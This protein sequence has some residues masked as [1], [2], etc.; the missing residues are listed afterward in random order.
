VR[1]WRKLKYLLPWHRRAQ[2][3]DMREE[4]DSL[5][6]LAAPGELGSL[7]LAAENAREVWGW[8]W[9]E[10]FGRDTRIGTRSLLRS[11]GFTLFATLI[12]S[13]GIGAMVTVVAC[14]NALF[15]KTLHVPDAAR[16]V[17]IYSIEGQPRPSGGVAYSTYLELR[18][19]NSS[20]QDIGILSSGKSFP[21]RLAGPRT[22]PAAIVPSAAVSNGLFKAIG[23]AMLLGR[24]VEATDEK[25][26][27][28]N[29]VVLNEEAWRRYFIRD[30][31]ILERAI[32]LDNTPYTIIGVAPKSFEDALSLFS[33][34]PSPKV[35]IPVRDNV[36][37]EGMV[38]VA[39]RLAHGVSRT[40]AG[41]D[42][43]RIA[44]Q[45]STEKN[46]VIYATVE[47]AD[48]PPSWLV[49]NLAVIVSFFL[50]VVFTLLLI[51]CDDIAI[52]LFARIMARQREMGI[53]VA[54]GG[55]RSQLVRQLLAENI[56][57]SIL[58]GAGAMIL[59]LLASRLIERLPVTLPDMSRAIFEWRTLTFTILISLATTLFF[60]LKPALECV[61]HD[62]VASLSPGAKAPNRRHGRVRS[63]LVVGQIAACT[64]LL[65]TAAVLV[66]SDPFRY[67]WDPL[68]KTD[69]LWLSDI[70]FVGTVYDR[71]S[72][73]EF[74][75]RLL[76]RLMAEPGIRSASVMNFGIMGTMIQSG[77]DNM[78]IGTNIL[79]IDEGYFR[80]L[81]VPVAGRTFNESDGP[82]AAPV[83]IVNQ[84]LVER[85]ILWK[86]LI[87][88]Q[89]PIGHKIRTGKSA[90]IEIVGV[91]RNLFG[92][93]QNFIPVLYRPLGQT[94]K[95]VSDTVTVMV[96][97]SG[98]AGPVER[99]VRDKVLG[100]DSSLLVH[101]SRTFD[102]QQ[103]Q[104]MPPF[105]AFEYGIGIPGLFAL[106]LGIVGTYGTVA[107]L[108]AQR[109]HE[110]GIRIAL[111]ARPST[112]VRLLLADG[113]K[114]ISLGVV[115]GIAV[116]L[117]I[118]LWL[119]RTVGEVAV[120]DPVAFVT[121]ALL[122]AATAGIACY[123]PAKRAS[124]VDPMVVLRED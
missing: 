75:R 45:L 11:P 26:G 1:I 73:L 14:F 46:S 118:L 51:A 68:F 108:V 89:D 97:Y 40:E 64:A 57:I 72:Q 36:K 23:V 43:K 113:I 16:F 110:V 50:V 87:R 65:I 74:Y 69:H 38:D 25:T 56:L 67:W 19:R 31:G 44:T 34:K 49:A 12:L 84:E 66:R 96:K 6:A 109:R 114:S 116:V 5:R 71:D 90:P 54:L 55:R 119:N 13:I 92:G 76:P 21:L 107:T 3:Q 88:G 94:Q 103:R 39:G 32:F 7:T 98:A 10:Q 20:L 91:V 77:P 47:R 28:P 15:F 63:N 111:G 53:R 2:E 37:P 101:N 80:T 61:S 104:E 86:D 115:C 121:M 70:N 112:A 95:A 124:L 42:F 100:V 83:G 9:L 17:R 27:A 22:L 78:V 24:G 93:P 58:G 30:R 117:I 18:D 59:I 8:V 105:R 4:L 99:I 60:G 41:A 123:V 102:D 85:L 79:S 81:Q 48:V 52:M 33:G 122:V 106:L 62:V 120:F 29:V 82:R 35:F